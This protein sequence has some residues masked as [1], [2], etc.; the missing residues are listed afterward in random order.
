[1]ISG[2]Q[3]TGLILNDLAQQEQQSGNLLLDFS[4]CRPCQKPGVHVHHNASAYQV[5]AVAGKV[6]AAKTDLWVDRAGGARFPLT[7]PA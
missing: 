4:L 6:D 1:M 7:N 5:E 2:E 3:L